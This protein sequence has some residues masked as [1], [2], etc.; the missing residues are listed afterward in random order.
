MRKSY[1]S[2]NSPFRRRVGL[3]R[4][5]SRVVCA[6]DSARPTTLD[7]QLDAGNEGLVSWGAIAGPVLADGGFLPN[8]LPRNLPNIKVTSTKILRDGDGTMVD[9]IP[10]GQMISLRV[11]FVTQAVPNGTR[12]D[13]L[14]AVDGV[15]VMVNDINWATGSG[16]WFAIVEGWY[17]R[18]GNRSLVVAIDPTNELAESDEADNLIQQSFIPTSPDAIRGNWLYPVGDLDRFD[19]ATQSYADVDPRTT[20]TVDFSGNPIAVSQQA[21]WIIRAANFTTQDQG[22]PILASASGTVVEVVDGN[23]DRNFQQLFG[24]Q[25]NYVLLDHGNGWQ[26]LYRNL[27]RDSVTVSPGQTVAA[28]EVLGNMGAS[29]QATGTQLQFQISRLGMPV[30]PMFATSEYFLDT[31]SVIYQ[32]LQPRVALDAV[33]ANAPTPSVADWNDG[34]TARSH[35]AAPR[36]ENPTLALW[37]NHLNA[38]DQTKFEFIRPNGTIAAT[39]EETVTS[40]T[41]LPR[42]LRSVPR[43]TYAS[44]PGVW[45]ARYSVNGEV[46]ASRNFEV[47]AATNNTPPQLAV[48]VSSRAVPNGQTTPFPANYFFNN[49]TEITIRNHGG[50]TLLLDS[51]QVP[52]GFTLLS[53]PSSIGSDGRATLRIECVNRFE[54][55]AFGEVRFSTNDP[56]FPEFSFLLELA[57][58]TPQPHTLV[59]LPSHD[60]AYRLGDAPIP[61][62]MQAQ[63]SSLFAIPASLR[64]SWEGGQATGDKL[65]LIPAENS[66]IS[67]VGNQVSFNG[68]TVGTVTSD[69]QAGNPLLVAFN[70][71]ITV[72]AVTALL[73]TVHFSSTS[74][75]PRP[76]FVSAQVIDTF[77]MHSSNGVKS[78]RVHLPFTTPASVNTIQIGDGTN[79]R[80][81][82]DA[83]QLRFSELVA[84]EPDA[85]S[86]TRSDDDAAIEIDIDTEFSNGETIAT[87]RFIGS[88]T[89]F[90]SL[91]DGNYLLRINPS[92]VYRSTGAPLDG[93]GDGLAGGV[94]EFGSES[95]DAFFRLLG[96]SNGNRSVDIADFNR[97]RASFGST[98]GQANFNAD[99]DFND[100]NS[101][102]IADFNRFRTNFGR[103]LPF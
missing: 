85:I 47:V 7:P 43:S 48:S 102:G 70:S 30:E 20:H 33:I 75:L 61:L 3:E 66:G 57:D 9:S 23:F 5:E 77:G 35:F 74:S 4:L 29:G 82:I 42:V 31:Q 54:S 12:F 49:I 84:I 38:G 83:V 67:V 103:S 55:K 100:D 99:F 91:P 46:L 24:M 18:P 64:I 69:G 16:S 90:G 92:K 44:H 68:L 14:F 96:D 22:I 39:H 26:S 37:L 78:I 10:V 21:G 72:P 52:E 51:W 62:D 13:I 93:D 94:Y 36:I 27:A 89:D 2:P 45:T 8:S 87:L 97:F 6:G 65:Q 60:L 53:A 50:Q 88:L 1:T 25:P 79:S 95:T 19:M 17:A 73:R 41:M 80:S 81:R 40:R 28:G 76:R 58:T 86:I 11:D 71:Q 15:T 101:V 63:F 59:T 98:Q 34:L 56:R 32:P